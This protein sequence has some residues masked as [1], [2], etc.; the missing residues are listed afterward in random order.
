MSYPEGPYGVPHIVETYTLTPFQIALLSVD[1]THGGGIECPQLVYRFDTPVDLNALAAAWAYAVARHPILRSTCVIQSG[2]WSQRVTS[3]AD[4]SLATIALSTAGA[5]RDPDARLEEFLAHDRRCGFDLEHELPFR[6]TWIEEASGHGAMVWTFH[7][8][9]GDASSAVVVLKDVFRRY[10]EVI[11][12]QTEQGNIPPATS[13]KHYAERIAVPAPQGLAFWRNYLDGISEIRPVPFV[14]R[15]AG[16]E[17]RPLE[18]VV[19]R[20]PDDLATALSI[21]ASDCGVAM[22]TLFYA[23]WAIVLDRCGWEG[24]VLFGCSL[25]TRDR[26]LEEDMCG[27]AINILPLRIDVPFATEVEDWLRSIRRNDRSRRPYLTVPADRILGDFDLSASGGTYPSV[28]NWLP[29]PLHEQVDEDGHGPM[30]RRWV[31]REQHA[32]SLVL[33]IYAGVEGIDVRLQGHQALF[34]EEILSDVLGWLAVA[35]EGLL[36]PGVPVGHIGLT[37]GRETGTALAWGHGPEGPLSSG[38][39]IERIAEIAD[40]ADQAI[41][42][43]DEFLSYAELESRSDRLA[44]FLSEAGVRRGDAVG[45]CLGRSVQVAVAIWGVLKAGAAYLPLDPRLPMRR[46]QSMIADSGS[47]MLLADIG[48]VSSVVGQVGGSARVLVLDGV[49][50]GAIAEAR[51]TDLPPVHGSDLAYLIF[52]SGSTGVPKGVAVEHRSLM[53]FAE[54]QS[55]RF[56]LTSADR[57]LQFSSLSFDMSVGDMFLAWMAGGCLCVATEDE[58]LGQD[59][60]DR[61]RDSRITS[62]MLPPAALGSLPWFPGALPDLRMLMVGG[63]AFSADLV[64]PWAQDRRVVTVYGPTECTVLATS[65]EFQPGTAPIIGSPLANARTYV[66]DSRLEPVPSGV[67]GELFIAGSGVSRGYVRRPGLTAERFV[68]DPFGQPGDRMYRTGDLVRRDRDGAMQFVGRIDGQVK[69]RGFRI[70][71]GEIEKV[72]TRHPGVSRVVVSAHHENGEPDARLVAYILG[73]DRAGGRARPPGGEALRAWVREYLPSYMVPEI[74]MVIE[75]IPITRSGKVDRAALPTPSGVRPSTGQIY[76]APRTD[77]QRILAGVWA[78]VL[79]VDRVGVHDNFFD[80]G[81]NSMRMMHVH[82]RLGEHGLNRLTLTDAFGHPTVAALAALADRL[83][84]DAT[85]LDNRASLTRGADRH[86]RLAAIRNRR[87]QDPMERH[88]ND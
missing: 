16:A 1:P 29:A 4:F 58:R 38:S 42:C 81:G 18:P 87:T 5:L 41:R 67:I 84:D 57:I 55:R 46:I 48:T 10:D 68:A 13:F 83:T 63:E 85:R 7:H 26:L 36:T 19:W 39:V 74:F 25:S 2:Q 65:S 79:G 9:A 59:L 32:V 75:S 15:R 82:A 50:G 28:I 54:S 8:A 3:E 71:L 61:L 80:L 45:V 40:P 23:A 49:D 20:I 64:E 70:E 66:L 12:G 35:L 56:G 30:P 17:R 47:Q 88:H 21:R 72:L 31:Q 52:T 33:D 60:F 22:S 6:V 34:D 44:W 51:P 53:N 78:K 27:P 14:R 73:R 76:V 62:A 77:T 37:P 24:D 69:I 86:R 11:A 43:G